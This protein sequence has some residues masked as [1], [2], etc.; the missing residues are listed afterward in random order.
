MDELFY[1]PLC[2]ACQELLA[3]PDFEACF[4][5]AE[6]IDI[7]ASMANLKRFLAY[8]DS[9]EAFRPMKDLGRVGIPV[10]ISG[11]RNVEFF[12]A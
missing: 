7:G 10:R 1:S 6:K 3:S 9:L 5:Q 11:G 12:G 4:G 8:R 2:P